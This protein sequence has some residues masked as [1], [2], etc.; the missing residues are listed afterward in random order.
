MF[1]PSGRSPR[2]RHPTQRIPN[3]GP[4]QPQCRHFQGRSRLAR[5]PAEVHRCSAGASHT[6]A[7][8]PVRPRRQ[9]LLN[10]LRV[11]LPGFQRQHQSGLLEQF[12]PT[13]GRVLTRDH[14][15]G[16]G[17]RPHFCAWWPLTCGAKGTRTPGL[18]DANHILCVSLRRRKWPEK[19]FTCRYSWRLAVSIG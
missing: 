13:A 3:R 16:L 4:E 17:R 14:D 1:H 10:F 15:K 5:R 7:A 2:R 9:H 8:E 12:V 6:R 19:L 18:L 11:I